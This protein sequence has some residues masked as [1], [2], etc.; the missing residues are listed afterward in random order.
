MSD[1]EAHGPIK[2]QLLVSGISFGDGT[3]FMT[4]DGKPAAGPGMSSSSLL[5]ELNTALH[6]QS[7]APAETIKLAQDKL[8]DFA[9]IAT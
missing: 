9:W 2:I 5:L 7:A 3:G 8:V 1:Y 4:T 6:A